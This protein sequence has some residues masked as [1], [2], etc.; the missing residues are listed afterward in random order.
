MRVLLE[1]RRQGGQAGKIGS[2]RGPSD[3]T[4]PIKRARFRG[5]TVTDCEKEMLGRKLLGLNHCSMQ[6][7]VQSCQQEQTTVIVNSSRGR[8]PRMLTMIYIVSW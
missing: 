7:S 8:E 4:W 6:L 2:V 3:E 1:I 5:G